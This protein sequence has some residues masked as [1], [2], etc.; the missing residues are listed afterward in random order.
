MFSNSIVFQRNLDHIYD[1]KY[2]FY[3][4]YL[5]DLEKREEVEDFSKNKKEKK[6]DKNNLKYFTKKLCAIKYKRSSLV[7]GE[8]TKM[9]ESS[10][11][12]SLLETKTSIDEC[13]TSIYCAPV[14][15]EYRNDDIVYKNIERIECKIIETK[16]NLPCYNCLK[17]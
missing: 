11:Y 4:S 14:S 1:D 13:H 7:K 6:C 10:G 8:N 16:T 5:C 2:D 9:V 17:I 15:E 3:T 12:R